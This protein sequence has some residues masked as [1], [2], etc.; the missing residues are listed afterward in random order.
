MVRFVIWPLE[1]NKLHQSFE[2]AT[3]NWLRV[4]SC[5]IVTASRETVVNTISSKALVLVP[6][7]AHLHLKTIRDILAVTLRPYVIRANSTKGPF[8]SS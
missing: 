5:L 2:S 3:T 6:L 7:L 8:V 1:R 4:I